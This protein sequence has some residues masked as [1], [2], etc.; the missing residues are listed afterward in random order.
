MCI[1]VLKIAYTSGLLGSLSKTGGWVKISI[2][3]RFTLLIHEDG[4][5]PTFLI[6]VVRKDS[7]KAKIVDSFTS[8]RFLMLLNLGFLV[9]FK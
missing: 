2:I 7:L 3:V 1:I 9:A 6:Y 4:S 5:E 8:R